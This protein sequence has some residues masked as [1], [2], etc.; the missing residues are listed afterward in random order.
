M[1]KKL[2]RTVIAL[3]LLCWSSAATAHR[4]VED[5]IAAGGDG[6]TR[7]DAGD[8]VVDHSEDAITV[9]YTTTGGW[10]LIETGIHVG[11]SLDDFPLT[12][13]GAPN[14]R[15]FAYSSDHDFDDSVQSFTY[16]IPA[17]AL[18]GEILVAANAVVV[19]TGT[20]MAEIVAFSEPGVDAWG[21]VA[22]YAGPGD[23]GWGSSKSAVEAWMH[24]DWAQMPP[25]VWISTDEFAEEPFDNDSWRRF[26]AQIDVDVDGFIVGGAVSATFD[27]AA[28]VYWNGVFIGSDGEV[29]G[30]IGDSIERNTIREYAIPPM[31]GLN[32]LDFIVRDYPCDPDCL[33]ATTGL[34]YQVEVEYLTVETAW[35]GTWDDYNDELT[36]QFATDKDWAAYMIHDLDQ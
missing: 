3:F 24:P 8:V 35:A 27:N 31:S 17:G 2:I 34:I 30:D 19:D 16:T 10:V 25:A 23:S 4:S 18:A 5:L 28:E 29:Q 26:Q 9:T 36:N 22:A 1:M 15:H 6:A 20:S 32:T 33:F 13:S 7:I 14:V 12:R 11:Q 21:P